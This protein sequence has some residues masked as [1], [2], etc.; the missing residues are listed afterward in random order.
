MTLSRSLRI[1]QLGLGALAIILAMGISFFGFTFL[2]ERHIERRFSEELNL[3]FNAIAAGLIVGHDNQ[4]HLSTS[5]LSPQ[6]DVPLSGY[7][8]RVSDLEHGGDIRSRSLWDGDLPQTRDS[9][10]AKRL[11]HYFILSRSLMLSS[12]DMAR[13]VRIE[14]AIDTAFIHKARDE[15]ASDLA[16]YLLLLG[17][18]LIL[19]IWLQIELGLLPLRGLRSAVE[20]L[21]NT[22]SQ[23]MDNNFANE[24]L[25]LTQTINHL[26]DSRAQSIEEAK[27]RAADLAHGLKSP[28]AALRN[29]S[30]KLYDEGHDVASQHL[31][32]LS[33]GLQ[34]QIDR[35]LTRSRAEVS[36]QKGPVSCDIDTLTCQL[37]RVLSNTAYG[38]V[39][40]W[41]INIT[42]QTYLPLDMSDMAEALGP[43][44][45]NA[46]RHAT[47]TVIISTDDH[48]H[49]I[50]DDD[51]A[52]M[53]AQQRK[54]AVERGIRFDE[55][56]SSTGLG[57]SIASSVLKPYGWHLILDE[58]PL[59]GLRVIFQPIK[60]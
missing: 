39:L 53:T 27:N 19:L 2:F 8:W 6:F 50:I 55:R 40:K 60:P 16:F 26:M 7:Y 3:H 45:E 43:I 21:M 38:E 57:L 14:V 36:V 35:E 23:R 22:P 29:L 20:K 24:V 34:R 13:R 49:L 33:I 10:H 56:S 28:L 48:C 37:V 12:T 30:Q 46:A 15:F 1:R 25:P 51:G 47:K 5:S 44:L 58:S 54:N 32:E 31:R 59:G 11:N 17:T 9:Q 52:G 42:P 41:Q 18:V 4:L